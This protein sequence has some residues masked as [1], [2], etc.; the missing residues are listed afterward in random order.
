L[1][2]HV[3]RAHVS[4]YRILT[5]LLPLILIVLAIASAGGMAYGVSPALAR[6]S[7][8]LQVIMLARRLQWPLVSLS[9]ILCLVLLVLVISGKRRAWWLIGLAPVLAL[10]AHR[11]ATSPQTQ[12]SVIENP[13][14]V[15]ADEA[16]FLHDDDWVVGISFDDQAYAFP[17]AQLYA[18]PVVIQTAREKRMMLM[19]SPLANFARAALVDRDLHARELDI[20][21]MPG[22]ATLIYNRRLGQFINGITGQAPDGSSPAGIHGELITQKTTWSNWLAAH[23]DTKVMARSSGR[24]LINAPNGPVL[25]ANPI[26]RADSDAK[27]MIVFVPTTQPVAILEEEVKSAPLNLMAGTLPVLIFRDPRTGQLR[28]FDRRIEQDLMPRFA[29]NTD[30]KRKDVALVDADTNS[31]WSMQGVAVDGEKSLRGKKLRPIDVQEDLYWGVMKCWYP[32]L[33]LVRP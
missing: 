21:S 1:T 3:L 32:E 25:P 20:V 33:K 29:L 10:F 13:P 17:Y 27:K 30:R 6:Y 15:T 9:I 11:F 16:G 8:G 7:H 26:P 23:R 24:A 12:F 18:T 14:M 31:G 5:V 22:N 19:W 28:A 4:R 2:H